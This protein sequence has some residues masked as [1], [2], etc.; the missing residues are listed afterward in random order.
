MVIR[1]SPALAESVPPPSPVAR[2]SCAASRASEIRPP[3]VFDGWQVPSTK[4]VFTILRWRMR[5]HQLP[6]SAR[7]RRRRHAPRTRVRGRRGGLGIGNA[8]R[9][10][11]LNGGGHAP[12]RVDGLARPCFQV[13][14][15]HP[16]PSGEVSG[17]TSVWR[18]PPDERLG[19]TIAPRSA[20]PTIRKRSPKRTRSRH[21]RC[22]R[23]CRL[24]GRPSSCQ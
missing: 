19:Q 4:S 5:P 13:T 17:E 15:Q 9:P 11:G 8:A 3:S 16:L 10:P 21:V 18:P 6:V 23:R 22:R 1:A 24:A 7:G 2:R 14:L 20:Q 12:L